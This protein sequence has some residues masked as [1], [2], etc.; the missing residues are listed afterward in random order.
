ML[1]FK[2]GQFMQ[3]SSIFLKDYCIIRHEKFYMNHLKSFKKCSVIYKIMQKFHATWI[4]DNI[5]TIES[6]IAYQLSG[7]FK[8]CN[9]KS[10]IIRS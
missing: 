6:K 1:M 9:V 10:G 7:D 5:F 4:N 8:L 3:R 2:V